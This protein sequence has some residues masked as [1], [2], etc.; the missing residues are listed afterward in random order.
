[1]QEKGYRALKK[2]LNKYHRFSFPMPRK[3]QKFT[4]Q[5]KSAI[6]RQANKILET[7][8]RVEKTKASFIPKPKGISLK[9]IPQSIRTNKGV[10]YPQPGAIIKKVKVKGHWKPKLEIR[11]K[12]LIEKYFAFPLD[13]LGNMELMVEWVDYL[14]AKYKPKYI[15]WA[16]NQFMGRVRYTPEAFDQYAGGMMQNKKFK[17]DFNEARDDDNNFLTG[18]FLGFYIP[19]E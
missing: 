4:P 5:Q 13:I 12:K 17:K 9:S 7:V 3:G 10:F 15:M 6:T 1:M 11:F 14:K 8:K 16:V 2:R 18:V 19:D